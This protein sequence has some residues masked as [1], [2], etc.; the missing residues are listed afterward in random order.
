M[1]AEARF[2]EL[3]S[4]QH[5]V[6]TR[7]DAHLV[8]LSDKMIRDRVRKGRLRVPAPGVL[9]VTGHPETWHRRLMI[10]VLA[11]GPTCVASHRSAAAL[12]GFDGFRPG[13][14]EVTVRRG[15]NYRPEGIRVHTSVDLGR[16]ERCVI[17]NIPATTPMRT[18]LDLGSVVHLHR[19]EEAFDS[20]ERD[21]AVDRVELGYTR[22]LFSCRGRAG[23]GP[24]A[25]L[26]D[27]RQGEQ[28][29]S[30][31]ER[32]MLRLLDT[33]C[34]PQPRCQHRI[35][36]PDGQLADLD[37]A[38]PEAR[39][40]IEV[41]GHVGHATR[42]QRQND[43]RRGTQVSLDGWTLLRFTWEDVTERPTYVAQ[44]VRDA[45]RGSRAVG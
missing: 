40:A 32:R 27:Q 2:A 33:H 37:F 42:R 18:L 10:A 1:D 5:G 11:G 26:V 13:P 19:L 17:D 30:V 36:R 35:V 39:I 28:P 23:L 41:E 29:R 3:A 44:A 16:T 38:Y 24:I 14:V 45:L 7:Y 9:V 43:A 25:T 8:G 6:G 20:A 15:R 21:G 34:L 31:L 12:H 22:Q 4:R